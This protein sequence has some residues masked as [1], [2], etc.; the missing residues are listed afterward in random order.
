MDSNVVK[1]DAPQIEDAVIYDPDDDVLYDI[2][3]PA[4][5]KLEI[6]SDDAENAAWQRVREDGLRYD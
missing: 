1:D 3:L 2:R 4:R 6:T 5:S